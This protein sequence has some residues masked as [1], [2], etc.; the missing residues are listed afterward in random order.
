MQEHQWKGFI[1]DSGDVSWDSIAFEDADIA[2]GIDA[3]TLDWYMRKFYQHNPD[4][5]EISDHTEFLLKWHFAKYVQ[6]APVLTRGAVMLFGK[7]Q[8]VRGLTIRPVLD[9]QRYDIRFENWVNTGDWQ[10]RKEFEGNLFTTWQSLMERYLRMADHA[11]RI[12]PAT[13]SRIDEPPDLIAFRESAANLLIHQDYSNGAKATIRWFI[14]WMQFENPGDARGEVLLA[15]HTSIPRNPLIVD[16][17]RRIR[18]S[19]EAGNRDSQ[20]QQKLARPSLSPRTD[21]ER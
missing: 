21:Q 16:A 20:N 10:D 15:S 5:Q 4:E 3:D 2:T 11:S 18:L 6:D 14:D 1:L 7:I 12:D 17:F 19:E 8:F 9:Y 13:M